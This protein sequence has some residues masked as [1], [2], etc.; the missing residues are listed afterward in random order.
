MHMMGPTKSQRSKIGSPN[1]IWLGSFV[2][3]AQCKVAMNQF[4]VPLEERFRHVCGYIV[5]VAGIRT[6]MMGPLRPNPCRHL[7]KCVARLQ[8]G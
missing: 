6:E 3:G 2:R 5:S 7:E 1:R 8:G 4:S